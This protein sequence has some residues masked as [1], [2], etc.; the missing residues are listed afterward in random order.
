MSN[1]KEIVKR[2]YSHAEKPPKTIKIFDT[3]DHQ[4]IN[5]QDY[6][7][8]AKDD[9]IC[10]NSIYLAWKPVK[11]IKSE[12]YSCYA[13][14][15]THFDK[16]IDGTIEDWK[17]KVENE[18][19]LVQQFEHNQFIIHYK[20]LIDCDNTTK[21]IVMDWFPY[22]DLF[23][24]WCGHPIMKEPFIQ[25]ILYQTLSALESLHQRNIVHNDIKLDNLLIQSINPVH[26]VLTDF[27]NAVPI[28]ECELNNYG[29][30]LF[31]APEI[32]EG[33]QHNTKADIWAAGIMA[34]LLFVGK[35]PFN[36]KAFSS[37]KHTREMLGR[38]QLDERLMKNNMSLPAFKLV[39]SMLNRDPQKR[40]SAADALKD[41][42]FKGLKEIINNE[43][44]S[45]ND[46]D[47]HDNNAFKDQK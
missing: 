42:Y 14:K 39:K 25:R 30:A 24:Y 6:Q 40:I 19:H 31:M 27:E 16:D 38:H 21:Y 9:V 20:D 10:K 37:V 12:K 45:G 15:T 18:Y 26:V 33:I 41:P 32:C 7:I 44:F 11:D 1:F 8:F 3:K 29:S 17:K 43:L 34:H 2:L 28:E 35:P 13:F 36:L 23:E 5:I 47:L 46:I 22:P 4:P